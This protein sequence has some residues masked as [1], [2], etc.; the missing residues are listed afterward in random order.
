MLVT[1]SQEGLL[2]NG[3]PRLGW[4]IDYFATAPSKT[5]LAARTQLNYLAFSGILTLIRLQLDCEIKP[6]GK[7]SCL[8]VIMILHDVSRRKRQLNAFT[9]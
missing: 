1:R 2:F 5:G 3:T 7:Q 9:E 4:A 8:A 6:G